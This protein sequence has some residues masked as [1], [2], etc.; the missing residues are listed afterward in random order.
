VGDLV[1]E[2][3]LRLDQLP[4]GLGELLE[5]PALLH[6]HR[7]L[8]G[9]LAE[10]RGVL[11]REPVP[12]DARE[13]D[14]ADRPSPGHQRP[15]QARSACLRERYAGR[16]GLRVLGQVGLEIAD[17]ARLSARDDLLQAAALQ[18]G[19]VPLA[20]VNLARGGARPAGADDAP[21]LDQGH[22]DPVERDQGWK[23]S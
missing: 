6:D 5:Q 7:Q 22:A 1:L 20:E 14:E 19:R 4:V 13:E 17:D 8:P 16:V 23:W 12:P 9:D 21:V 10:Q 3:L 2:R 15:G 11:V 18:R